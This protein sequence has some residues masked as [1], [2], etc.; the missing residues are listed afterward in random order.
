MSGVVL[1]TLAYKTVMVTSQRLA[2]ARFFETD[3]FKE[4]PW[5]S[6]DPHLVINPKSPR[7]FAV[8][9]TTAP[10]PLP[11]GESSSLRPGRCAV[12]VS[13]DKGDTWL[14]SELFPDADNGHDGGVGVG[15]DGT[16]YG[17]CFT[18]KGQELRLSR[19]GG[20]TWT[21]P[22]PV[23]TAGARYA[24]GVPPTL[25]PGPNGRIR[26]DSSNGT[27]YFTSAANVS[28]QFARIVTASHDNG[29]T[30][31]PVYGVG[32]KDYPMFKPVNNPYNGGGL[33]AAAHGV[34]AVVYRSDEVPEPEAKCPCIVFAATKDEGKSFEGH[35]VPT[36]QTP[37][38]VPPNAPADSNLELL[39]VAFPAMIA[40]DPSRPGRF[41]VLVQVQDQTKLELSVTNDTGKTWS[42]PTMLG[43]MPANKRV[44]PYV[45]YSAKG[46]LGAAWRT[47]YADGRYDVYVA[48]SRDGSGKFG[49]PVRVNR[50]TSPRN[51]GPFIGY[52]D[53]TSLAIDDDFAHLA[54]GDWRSGKGDIWYARVPL[55]AVP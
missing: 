13:F 34:F 21:I 15:P 42:T 53:N 50:E 28:G 19:D 11:G 26:G 20:R 18:G 14:W 2:G 8:G 40:A 52:D 6:G 44:M 32:I 39:K 31:G 10:A 16:L 46:V 7:N 4:S 24:P 29:A 36:T 1:G 47:K 30:W 43:E 51:R 35:V 48:L 12:S 49:A 25:R 3:I 54:W 38:H 33:P 55:S 41:A 17:Y 23:L 27:V 45:E 37:I 22:Q 5:I 9:V